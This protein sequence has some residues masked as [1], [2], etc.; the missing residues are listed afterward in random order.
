MYIMEEITDSEL[1]QNYLAG[2]EGAL[3]T[4]VQRHFKRVFL[5]A[6]T[7]VKQDQQAEDVTQEVFVKVWKN[8]KKFD[9]E[10]K[11]TTWL[12]QITKNTCIDL[13]R[14][15]K[16]LLMAYQMGE[17]IMADSLEK[18]AD[19]KPLPEEVFDS[20]DFAEK[21]D[22]LINILPP[23][24][25]QVVRLHLQHDLTFQEIAEALDK[26]I[27]TIKSRYRRALISIQS[28]LA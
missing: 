20:Q 14:K 1:V 6:K 3:E 12:L 25:A 10:K 26:P 23:D 27:N 16:N 11:F 5:F 24:S 15:N 13:L 17:E 19:L 7:Y 4:I 21:L 2:D 9:S 28:K 8:L 22:M 18:M